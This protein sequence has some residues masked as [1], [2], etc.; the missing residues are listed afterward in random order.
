MPSQAESLDL[1]L[2]EF[3]NELSQEGESPGNAGLCDLGV[4]TFPSKDSQ[5]ATCLDPVLLKLDQ[6]LPAKPRTPQAMA[7][8]KSHGRGGFALSFL[9]QFLFF[10]RTG[11]LFNVTSRDF[12]VLPRL[13]QIVLALSQTKAGRG[14]AQSVSLFDP[15]LPHGYQ[16]FWPC[17]CLT[18]LCALSHF[19]TFEGASIR[20]WCS[21]SW[22]TQPYSFRRRN[23]SLAALA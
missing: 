9:V 1:L 11:E 18:C 23:T 3:T 21:A 12:Q 7:G 4:E 19:S 16:N 6:G 22:N 15:W 13:S 17:W 5:P 8:G 20:F 14:R 2:G 10:L